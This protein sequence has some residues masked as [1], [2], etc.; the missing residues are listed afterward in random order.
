MRR[1]LCLLI[2]ALVACHDAVAPSGPPAPLSPPPATPAPAATALEPVRCE[3]LTRLRLPHVTVTETRLVEAS[4]FA[5][6][7]P[8][9]AE[10]PPLRL[11]RHCRVLGVSRPT[12]DSEIR[13]EVAIPEGEAW[14]GRYEQVGNGA[15]AGKIHEGDVFVP[16]AAGFAAAGTDDGHEA[17]PADASWA[18]GHPEKVID[19][20]YRAVKETHDAAR[21]IIEAHTG[22]A[23]RFSYFS[24]C[25]T[26]GREALIQAQRYPDDFDGIVAGAPTVAFTH[27]LLGFAWNVQ[28]LEA[29]PASYIPRAKL[30]AIE[31]AALAACGDEDGVVEDPLACRFDPASLRCKG[32]DTPKCLT[33]AQVTALRKIYAGP[34]N[35][36][37][38]ELLEPG[39]EPG[40]EAE[41]H[42]P[43][44]DGWSFW[45]AGGAPGAA[46]KTGEYLL[47]Q[48]FFASMVF[49]DP[50]YDLRRLDFDGD[51]ATT[52]ARIS[53]IV[54][55]AA[56]DLGA[57]A[58]H[59][60]KLIHYQGWEDAVLAPRGSV[61]YHERVQAKMGDTSAF[62][63]LF[64]APG[65]LHCEGGR[66]PNVLATRD[67]ITAWVEHGTPPARL[68]ATKFVDDNPGNSVVR[69]RP[70]CP[71]PQ[72]ATWTGT[73]DRQRAESY[74]CSPPR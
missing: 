47:G 19:F 50:K 23:P 71:F 18:L 55:P 17:G 8:S 3:D 41:P 13:F 28:A 52:D 54:D 5:N 16:L 6:P 4:D 10:R 40:A 26:G 51:V 56:T 74:V 14:N 46:G 68:L 59:G 42:G 53:A 21:A 22:R 25:S 44:P 72:Q 66:G 48:T 60:G 64:M 43:E 29:T 65:M 63:R 62:Y 15:F 34:R 36:R 67:A 35:P 49:G 33:D 58:R 27:V 70:L 20:G 73:G 69:T 45:I 1:A 61:A 24:G 32:A 38:G 12:A 7:G 31:A 30:E 39:F 9:G 57:F 2:L 37:T 11:P